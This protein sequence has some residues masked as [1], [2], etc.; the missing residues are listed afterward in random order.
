[1]SQSI[2]A[3]D[4]LPDIHDL[5]DARLK[6][7]GLHI[8]HALD[9]AEGMHKAVTLQPDLILLDIDMPEV[10]GFELCQQLQAEPSTAHI[11]II[12]LSGSV[13]VAIKVRGLELG[14]VDYV[15]KPFDAAELRARVRAALRIKRQQDLIV[16]RAQVDALTGLWN[17]AHLNQQLAATISAVCQYGR[18]VCLVLIDLDHFKQINDTHGH[19][20]GDRVLQAVGEMLSRGVRP[21]DVACRYG[22]EEFAVILGDAN[23]HGGLVTALRLRERMAA[24]DLRIKGER[25][26]IR[27]SFGVACTEQ[28]TDLSTL[29]MATLIG[30]ADRALYEAKHAGRDRVCLAKVPIEPT[31]ATVPADIASAAS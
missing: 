12:F 18:R 21:A 6:S 7:E 31:A 19:L 17:R 11:P 2:L 14:A 28:F 30:A 9:A 4:D 24:L 29:S 13:E 1:M 5:L 3:I 16:A 8:H 15:T 27:A 22:G 25:V 10:S 20:F 26:P 23:L